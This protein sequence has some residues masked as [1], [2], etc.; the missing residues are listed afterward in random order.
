MERVRLIA[1]GARTLGSLTADERRLLAQAL[2]ERGAPQVAER[3][4]PHT[5]GAL[6]GGEL[7]GLA[8]SLLSIDRAQLDALSASLRDPDERRRLLVAAS[9]GVEDLLDEDDVS[10][11][12][13]RAEPDAVPAPPRDRPP[14]GAPARLPPPVQPSP[15]DVTTAEPVAPDIDLPEVVTREPVPGEPVRLEPVPREHVPR[16]P[17]APE[18]VTPRPVAREP[19]PP[20]PVSTEPTRESRGPRPVAVAPRPVT[21]DGRRTPGRTV[22]S[23][24]VI[25]AIERATTARGRLSAVA[26]AEAAPL[27]GDEL[28]AIVRAVPDG[29]QRRTAAR[30]LVTAGGVLAVDAGALVASLERRSDR[31]SLAADLLD[32]G[33]ADVSAIADHLDARAADRLR[34][35]V[36]RGR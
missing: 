21:G 15:V 8:R 31:I 24:D 23:R 33:L 29:W 36:A 27:T 17:V 35:H 22:D 6:S 18:P 4:A 34:R 7:T 19:V 26:T 13:G 2:V 12:T 28:L 5:A 20:E 1:G 10:A 3:I 11:T 25:G 30:R 16:E 9:G 32:A 14:S